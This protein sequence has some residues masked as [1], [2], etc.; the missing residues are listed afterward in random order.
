MLWNFFTSS[1]MTRPNKLECLSFET[2]SNQVLEFEGKA[3]ADPIRTHFRCSFLGKL[4]VLPANVRLDWK[5]I[6]SCKH[7]SLFGLVISDEWKKFYNI[8]TWCQ[9]CKTFSL[10][11]KCQQNK[12]EHLSEASFFFNLLSRIGVY[13]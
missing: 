3:R 4:L 12:L 8:D 6:A 2:L 1:L 7:S 10:R 11:H 13:P 9:G 5:V